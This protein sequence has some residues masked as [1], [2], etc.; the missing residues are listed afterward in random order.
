MC[1]QQKYNF[2]ALHP[3]GSKYF[4]FV[5]ST[6]LANMSISHCSVSHLSFIYF[7]FLP[8]LGSSEK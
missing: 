6:R 7:V 3:Y 8:L 1:L 2:T 5:A 4:I